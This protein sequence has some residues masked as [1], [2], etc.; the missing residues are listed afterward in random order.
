MTLPINLWK[1]SAAEKPAPLKSLRLGTQVIQQCQNKK[2]PANAIQ[3]PESGAYGPQAR[4][5]ISLVS[6]FFS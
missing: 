6:R 2:T 4:I 1:N 5:L 3:R